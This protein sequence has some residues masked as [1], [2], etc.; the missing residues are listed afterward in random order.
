MTD[1]K[2]NGYTGCNRISYT[3]FEICYQSNSNITKQYL[4]KKMFSLQILL[5]V[6]NM[7]ATGYAADIH[8]IF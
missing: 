8:T 5:Q 2:R 3:T 4:K 6:F 7:A 1:N